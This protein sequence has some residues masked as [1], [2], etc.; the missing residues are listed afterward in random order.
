LNPRFKKMDGTAQAGDTSFAQ[1]QLPSPGETWF[2][3]RDGRRYGWEIGIIIVVKLAVLILLWFVFIKP[4]PRPATPPAVVVQQLY[5]PAAPAS[6][7]D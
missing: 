5:S 1:K 4:W 6:R 7:H 3:T 2:R